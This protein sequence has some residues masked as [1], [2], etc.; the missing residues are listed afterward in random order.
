MEAKTLI[1]WLDKDEQWRQDFFSDCKDLE[2]AYSMDDR[3][4]GDGVIDYNIFYSNVATLQPAIYARTPKPQ[5][6]RRFKDKDNIGKVASQL[7]ERSVSF[8]ISNYDFDTL[9]KAVRDDYLRVGQ[10]VAWVRYKPIY[11]EIKLQ[12]S[13]KPEAGTTSIIDDDGNEYAEEDVKTASDGSLF[14]EKVV[15]E[16]VHCDY[17]HWR[18]F[19]TN[20]AKNWNE[21]RRVHRRVYM[22]KPD[23]IARFGQ[24]KI[25]AIL[26]SKKESNDKESSLNDVEQSAGA[27]IEVYEIWHKPTKKVYWVSRIAETILDVKDDPLKL[28]DFFPCPRPILS[29]T[30]SSTIIPIADYKFYQDQAIS[31]T[32]LSTRINLL[33]S[34]LAVQGVFDATVPELQNLIDGKAKNRLIPVKNWSY[35]KDKGGLTGSVDFVPLDV[36][37]GVIDRLYQAREQELNAAY[38]ISGISDV[39]RGYSDPSTTATAEQ[40]KG[41]FATLR[42]SD[43]QAEMQRF[44]RDLIALKAEIIAEHFSPETI[45]LMAGTEALAEV[46]P[47]V[48]EQTFSQAIE[49]L[50]NDVLRQYRISIETDSTLA[51]DEASE[52][53]SAVEFGQMS[54]QLIQQTIGLAQATPELLPMAKEIMMFT[55]RRFKAGRNLEATIESSFD[56]LIQSIQQQQQQPQGPS[57]EEMQLQFEQEK[58]QVQIQAD[59]MKAQADAQIKQYELQIKEQEAQAKMAIEAQKAEFSQQIS[60]AKMNAELDLKR[61]KLELETALSAERIRAQIAEAR[62]NL[63]KVEEPTEKEEPEKPESQVPKKTIHKMYDGNGQVTKIVEST[64]IPLTGEVN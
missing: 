40:I 44:L 11:E 42:I 3:E 63:G 43:R 35:I 30:T 5:V 39:I 26:N 22:A 12:V 29:T 37:V 64:E 55:L 4:E 9:A 58:A 36:I 23:A 54:S 27:D 48:Q 47:S 16:E 21:V 59:Q 31:I 33:T 46:D 6:E 51:I 28:K 34:A 56:N 50:R 7:L 14:T 17:V 13:D 20:K 18:D 41:Q 24:D 62:F 8:S 38:Q 53:E 1:S 60:I 32:D 61:Q 45:Y 10:G 52:K 57:P 19:G 25:D 49:L 15:Y 2:E